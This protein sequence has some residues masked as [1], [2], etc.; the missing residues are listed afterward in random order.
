M[1]NVKLTMI[2]R[3]A[4]APVNRELIGGRLLSIKGRRWRQDNQYGVNGCRGRL[5]ARLLRPLLVVLLVA[6]GTAISRERHTIYSQHGF[7]ATEVR[8]ELQQYFTDVW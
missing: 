1:R 7:S 2:G 5:R 3:I 4:V 6:V 8:R